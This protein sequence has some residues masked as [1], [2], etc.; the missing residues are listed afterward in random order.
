MKMH[1]SP[2]RRWQSS[3]YAWDITISHRNKTDSLRVKLRLPCHRPPTVTSTPTDNQVR[4]H[5][6]YLNQ[7]PGRVR[8]HDVE[9]GGSFP[10]QV[11]AGDNAHRLSQALLLHFAD[12]ADLCEEK[13]TDTET[14]TRARRAG[15]ARLSSSKWN[16]NKKSSIS[17]SLYDTS[18]VMKASFFE[19]Y[20]LHSTGAWELAQKEAVNKQGKAKTAVANNIKRSCGCS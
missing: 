17:F 1:H 2:E 6:A 7:P 11:S 5:G 15:Y 14:H 13:N 19:Q 3:R 18:E 8:R 4:A 9:T 10:K 20:P 16:T 12:S